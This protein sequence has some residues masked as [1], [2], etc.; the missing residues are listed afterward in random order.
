MHL[1]GLYYKNK[2]CFSFYDK[3]RLVKATFLPVLDYSNVFYVNASAQN[4]HMLEIVYHGI[5]R[6]ITKC[7]FLI[8][9]CALYSKVSWT[10][11]STRWL[12]HW[13]IFIYKAIL[14]KFPVYLSSPLTLKDGIHNLR[15]SDIVRFFCFQST[16]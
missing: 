7:V 11:L 15:Y 12:A 16:N 5:L 13:Y 9:H 10:S 4:L 14:G 3:K 2:S 8:H 6:F 1:L